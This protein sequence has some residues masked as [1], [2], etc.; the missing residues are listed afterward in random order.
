MTDL[1]TLSREELIGELNRRDAPYWVH[2]E[3]H[4]LEHP[5]DCNVVGCTHF[6]HWRE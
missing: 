5:R 4:I 6:S 2:W 3:Y 1:D